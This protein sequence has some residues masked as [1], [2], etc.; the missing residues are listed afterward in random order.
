LTHRTDR[1]RRLLGMIAAS[2][3]EPSTIDFVVRQLEA[4]MP[5]EE[6]LVTKGTLVKARHG[7]VEGDP[8]K[9][10]LGIVTT[11]PKECDWGEHDRVDVRWLRSGKVWGHYVDDLVIVEE[12][13]S[14]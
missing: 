2:D 12:S 5:P 6:K 11:E 10:G 4:M 14:D 13:E 3:T 9:L 1:I 8:E 7:T